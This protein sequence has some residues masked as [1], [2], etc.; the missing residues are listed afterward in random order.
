MVKLF[1]LSVTAINISKITSIK[2]TTNCFPVS[3]SNRTT[4]IK[5][6]IDL[7]TEV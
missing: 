2:V 5:A 1:I 4:N 7:V 3:E 6:N